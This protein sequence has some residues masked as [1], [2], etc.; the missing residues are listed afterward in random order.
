MPKS[1]KNP[2]RTN[3]RRQKSGGNGGIRDFDNLGDRTILVVKDKRD[4]P[5]NTDDLRSDYDRHFGRVLELAAAAS[6]SSSKK[7]GDAAQLKID[8]DEYSDEESD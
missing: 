6:G 4:D 2:K 7:K 5:Q 8:V 1:K 3:R